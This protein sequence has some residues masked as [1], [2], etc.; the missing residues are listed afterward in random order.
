VLAHHKRWF[1]Y[2]GIL[3]P[4]FARCFCV[5]YKAAVPPTPPTSTVESLQVVL[6]TILFFFSAGLL[7]NLY[8]ARDATINMT[9]EEEHY[10][11]ITQP[12]RWIL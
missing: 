7:I 2:R 12:K 11:R 10:H 6:L 8:V 1:P 3:S 5:A 4:S 9:N